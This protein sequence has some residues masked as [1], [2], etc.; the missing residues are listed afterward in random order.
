VIVLVHSGV[1]D[2]RM[3]DGFDLPGAVRHEM[4]GFGNTPMPPAGSYSD[5]DDLVARLSEPA[6]LIG[7]SFGG[8]VCLEVAARRPELVS[9]LVLLDAR[10]PDHDWS[11]EILDY[12]RREDE[13]VEEGELHAAAVLTADFWVADSSCRDRVIEM[14]ERAYELQLESEAEPLETESIGLGAVRAPTLVVVG[15]LDKADFQHIAKR[16]A[17]EIPNAEHAVIP[18]AGHLPALERPDATSR[19]V[20]A[21]LDI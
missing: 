20:R 14:Q 3:W 17:R 5:A 11:Q 16:L 1:C 10:V 4:R 19:V 18:G 21:F 9:R 7:A 13:L 6:T 2:A 8:Q 12:G 15:E